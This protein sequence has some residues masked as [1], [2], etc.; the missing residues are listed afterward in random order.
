MAVEFSKE[1][2]YQMAE[3]SRGSHKT[4][5]AEE[6]GVITH[7]MSPTNGKTY[8]VT[9]LRNVQTGKWFVSEITNADGTPID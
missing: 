8:L 3:N 5:Q 2:L 7:S 1:W 4:M 9:H 6:M